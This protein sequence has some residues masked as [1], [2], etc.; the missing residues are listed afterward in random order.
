MSGDERKLLDTSGDYCYAVKSGAEV[1]DPDWQSCRV[2]LTN[3]RL[4]LASNGGKQAVAYENIQLPGDPDDAVPDSF[5][6]GGATPLRIGDNVI[7]VDATGV[8][9]FQTE[10]CRA[11]LHGTVILVKYPA[12]VGGVVQNAEWKK[13]RFRLAD[14]TVQLAFPDGDAVAFDVDDV[15]TLDVS[16]N[17][18]KGKSRTVVKVEHTDAEDRS[19]ETHFSGTA[20]HTSALQTLF[21]QVI[22]EREE[23]YELDEMENQVLMAL[24]S[25]VSPF[26]MADFVGLD[27]DEVEE[28][29]NTLLDVGAV[30]KVRVRTE[31]SL[32]AYGRNLASEAMSEQ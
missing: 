26:E 5:S 11:N 27:V 6:L 4:I 9:D 28:I 3:K 32:N 18:I 19:V 8:D 15:G 24:Y 17:D 30:D 29:Y 23:D 20:S 31:V 13:A 12:V 25:G 16:T 7:V 1:P 21:E 22:E 10:Y 2:I 14:D